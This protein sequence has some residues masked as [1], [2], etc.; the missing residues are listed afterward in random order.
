[1][2]LAACSNGSME[3][4]GGGQRLS[5]LPVCLFPAGP[6]SRASPREVGQG[7]STSPETREEKAWGVQARARLG[8]LGLPGPLAPNLNIK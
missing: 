8:G 1:M 6:L 3:R 5:A 4:C 7:T 2:Q